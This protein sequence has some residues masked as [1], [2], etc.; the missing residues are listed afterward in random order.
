MK[1]IY[2]VCIS[3]ITSYQLSAQCSGRY[4]SDIFSTVDVNTVTYG[5][6]LDLNS[7]NVNLTMDIYQPQGDT[8]SSRPLIIFAHGGSFSAGTKNDADIVYFAT[9]M[10]KKGYVCASINYR[11]APSAF[12]LIAEETT[13]KVVLMAMQDGKAAVRYF[14]QDAA[15]TNTYKI[16]TDQIFMGGTSAGG[17]LGI[18]MAYLDSTDVMSPSWQTWSNEVGG[19]E[20]NSGNPGYCSLVTGTFGFAGGVADPLWI[21][22]KD[23][24]WYGCH[25]E[26]DNTVKIGY[27]Q[28]LNGFT[29][30]FLY[31]SDSING[32]LNSLGIHAAYDR[33][34]GGAHPPFNGSSTIMQNNKDSL[35]AFLYRI[36]DC[37]PNNLKLPNQKSCNTSTGLADATENSIKAN[38]Y[39]NPTNNN[40]TIKLNNSF[41]LN[42]TRII[43]VNSIGEVL[44]NQLA[45]DYTNSINLSNFAQ[46]VYF[47][48]I[49]S[50]E[51]NYTQL[52]VKQ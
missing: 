21:D 50:N 28:P 32:R 16:D 44:V 3:L 41:D 18:N 51:S 1:K 45:T 19:L 40:V 5:S 23:V 38:I 30:V 35:A 48:R 7:N 43:L 10:A 31:G 8:S 14:R 47:V 39:P 15:T 34:S 36:L 25:A 26:T 12:S 27:G 13:V 42:N 49:T 20:G 37:N 17:I 33:Y 2:L 24:P 52:L 11:L 22:A 9:E 6:N 4:Q 29:P 46:G